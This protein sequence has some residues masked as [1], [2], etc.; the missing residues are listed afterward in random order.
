M[1]P[2]PLTA[3]RLTMGVALGLAG[4]ASAA[5]AQ[6]SPSALADAF[7]AAVIAEDKEAISLLYTEDADSYG[8][9]GDIVKGR[10]AIAD[11][12]TPMFDGF[13]N[14]TCELE[15]HGEEKSGKTATAWGLWTMTATPAGGGDM[16]TMRG[17]YMDYSVKTKNGWRYRADHASMS[18]PNAE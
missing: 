15:S 5:A 18:A 7:C 17:R 11:S 4:L 10:A 16:V 13:D 1:K 6:D 12:W 9:G 3:R 8:P 14:I 2:T